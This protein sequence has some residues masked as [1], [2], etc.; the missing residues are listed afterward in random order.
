MNIHAM[1]IQALIKGKTVWKL[2]KYISH[3]LCLIMAF[4]LSYFISK[5]NPTKGLIVTLATMVIFVVLG[6]LLFSLFGI[7]VYLSHFVTSIFII[8][9]IWVPFRAI[10]E[11]Q[12]RY[13]I[14]QESELL[15]K[16]DN[17]KQNF[18]SLMSHDLKTPVAKIAGVADILLLSL[19]H[20]SEPTRPY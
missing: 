9:Y 2:P 14:Q 15:K 7:W 13:K 17:L 4:L 20:I 5:Y 12:H 16:V 10:I 3:I 1:I 8:Y 6:F 18:I 19:I 11:Y